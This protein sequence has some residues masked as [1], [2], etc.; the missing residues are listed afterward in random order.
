VGRGPVASR[1]MH[2]TPRSS[3]T[4]GL[5]DGEDEGPSGRDSGEDWDDP[6]ADR[7]RGWI[8]PDDRLWRH[9]S[10]STSTG[11]DAVGTPRTPA[12]TRPEPRGHTGPWVFGGAAA[13]VLV[14]LVVA[15]LVVSTTNNAT[16]PNGPAPKQATLTDVPTT[17]PGVGLVPPQSTVDTMM[18][19]ALPSTVGLVVATESGTREATGLVAESG[20]IIVTTS[21]A[22]AGA[23]SVTVIEADGVRVPASAVG[24]DRTT[25]LSVLRIADDLP[26]ATFDFAPPTTGSVVLAMALEPGRHTGEAPS[27]ALYAGS[28][29]ASGQ[30]LDLDRFSSAFATTALA[31]PLAT[32]DIGCPLLDDKGH[33]TGMLERVGGTGLVGPSVFLPAE[34]VWSV[35][36][37]LVSSSSVDPGWIGVTAVNAETTAVPPRPDGAMVDDVATG[38]PAAQSGLEEGDVVTA[39]NGYRVLSDAELKT[40]MYSMPPGTDVKITVERSGS[41]ITETVQ[42]AEPPPDAPEAAASP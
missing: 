6:D 27:P 38:S 36:V 33:V 28:V 1:P 16:S 22:V 5:V 17:E 21:A 3:L 41:P 13:C 31:A 19:T 29:V 18:A 42:V 39:V 25:G 7:L 9:P 35:A 2:Q 37:Q 24:S 26:A 10:E 30:A 34:L 14:V 15:G 4:S 12:T 23:R 32:G 11:P 40:W 20:G 8:P